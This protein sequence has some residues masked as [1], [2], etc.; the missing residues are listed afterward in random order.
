MGNVESYYYDENGYIRKGNQPLIHHEKKVIIKQKPIIKKPIEIEDEIPKSTRLEEDALILGNFTVQPVDF[1]NIEA[2][3][4]EYQERERQIE[5]NYKKEKEKIKKLYK[6]IEEFNDKFDPYKILGLKEIGIT[7]DDIKKSY[8]KRSLQYHPDKGGDPEKFDLVK[9]AYISLLNKHE[10]DNEIEYRINQ[11]VKKKDYED[12]LFKGYR[13]VHLDKDNFNLQKFNE[14]FEKY[15]L[16]DE[17]DDGYEDI[18]SKEEFKED[19]IEYIKERNKGFDHQRFNEEKKKQDIMEYHE[20]QELFSS[21]MLNNYKELGR[22]K[23]N[24]FGGNSISLSYTDYKKAYSDESKFINPDAIQPK[25]YKS[26]QEYKRDRENIK[27]LTKEEEELI[28]MKKLR[29]EEQERERKH[30]IRE[31]DSLYEKQF[32]QYH[33]LMI[34]K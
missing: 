18:M 9:K 13:N 6:E 19:K 27:P 20:P 3:R 30:K 12:D 17:F 1:Q 10:K 5:E 31:R 26:L 4:K 29:E 14:I 22:D 28:K 11:E 33:G 25:T 34:E 24:D 2:K 32:K 16:S 8:R 23:V 15:K 7:L 21:S